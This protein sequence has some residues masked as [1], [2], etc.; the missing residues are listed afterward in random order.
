VTTVSV[1]ARQRG[2]V[3]T[4]RFTGDQPDAVVASAPDGSDIEAAVSDGGFDLDLATLA[5]VPGPWKIRARDGERWREWSDPFEG[6]ALAPWS[7]SQAWALFSLDGF[8][9]TTAVVTTREGGR[10]GLAVTR[11]RARS[12]RRG[13]VVTATVLLGPHG[14]ADL[15]LV[16]TDGASGARV[17]A[18]VIAG[19]SS[20]AGPWRAAKVRATVPWAELASGTEWDATIV[21]AFGSH[22]ARVKLK[23]PDTWR[24]PR[25]R[26]FSAGGRT[27]VLELRATYKARSLRIRAASLTDDAWR[28]LTRRRPHR[29]DRPL[30]LIGEL[31]DRA[32]DNGLALFRHLVAR[33]PEIDARYV[34][35]HDSPDRAA[36]EG[37]G[38]V[39]LHGSVEHARA[40]RS[41]ARIASTHHPDY[42][43]PMRT[44]WMRRRV[45]AVLVF[46]QHGVLAAKWVADLYGAR[47]S[48]FET[49]RFLVS[50]PREA[51]VVARDFGYS[52]DRIAVTGLSRFDTL[53]EPRTA[54]RIALVVPTWRPWLVDDDSLAGSDFAVQWSALLS[55]ARVRDAF[56][57]LDVVA[58]A[59][60]NL[61]NL[62]GFPHVR[63]AADAEPLQDLIRSAA[64]VLTDYS[65][66]GIDAALL[67]V[68]VVYFQF[69][70]QRLQGRTGPHE[71]DLP[72][73]IAL[74]ADAAAARVAEAAASGFTVSDERAELARSYFP[75]YDTNSAERVV[76]AIRSARRTRPPRSKRSLRAARSRAAA[77]VARAGARTV[78]VRIAYEVARLSPVRRSEVLFEASF[79]R[80]FADSPRAIFHELRRERPDLHCTWV[81]VSAP[82]AASV[83]RMTLGYA[84]LLATAGTLVSN[85]SLPHW[86]R[87]R[88]SQQYIQT[89]HGTPLKRMLHDLDHITGRDA[90]YVRRATRGAAQWGVLLSPNAHTTAAMA[91]AFRHSARVLE[92]GYPRNDIFFAADAAQRAAEAKARLGIAEGRKVVLHAPTFRDEG[93]DGRGVYVPTEAIDFRAFA[94]AFGNDATLV[95]R[96]HF[97]DRTPARIP[98]EAAHCVIDATGEQDVQDLLLAA[99][100]LVTDYSSVAFDFLVARRPS[101]FLAPDLESYRDRVRGFYLNETTDLPGPVVTAR[102]DFERALREALTTGEVDGYDLES[103]AARFA[104][105]DDGHAA[106]RVVAELFG[107]A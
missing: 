54:P 31:P 50:S 79:G 75:A 103:F 92:V 56:H 11:A 91:S 85:Q 98:P 81:G 62:D 3:V 24:A 86:I 30:W 80:Q 40:V 99:D 21:A 83:G 22:E 90:G 73:D 72:G 104:P 41:A 39:V 6:D 57:G 15:S 26:R 70:A 84:R 44:E 94:R 9:Q 29:G 65:S 45:G 100:V 27:A 16:L 42:L 107:R 34:I 69:D 59:H 93:L 36:A 25:A 96:R 102:D 37:V 77:Y 4:L 23:V 10:A 64:M 61:A 48:T 19:R 49:D 46:L 12:R 89:W 78:V 58:V 63:F 101:I 66:I 43:Y 87:T 20:T 33:H 97:L 5:G 8:P 38:P 2:S 7:D 32:R 18:P 82:G 17:T 52:R 55:D 106:Q 47:S 76:G 95:L 74:T 13:V 105:H 60:P 35:T 88:R 67:R 28:E 14:P 71:R 53:L 1:E 51:D 68:P